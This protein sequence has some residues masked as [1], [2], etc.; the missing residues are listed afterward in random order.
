M[1]VRRE[2]ARRRA[3]REREGMC[4]LLHPRQ[5][6]PPTPQPAEMGGV[7]EHKVESSGSF[8]ARSP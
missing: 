7:N 1:T 4:H 2:I 8:G 6:A 3:E 5:H